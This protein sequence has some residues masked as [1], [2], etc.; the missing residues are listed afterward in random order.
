MLQISNNINKY[1]FFI[2]NEVEQVK[3]IYIVKQISDIVVCLFVVLIL[4]KI[5]ITL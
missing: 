3:L 1:L 5:D 2:L 4:I